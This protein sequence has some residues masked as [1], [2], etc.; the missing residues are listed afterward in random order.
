[1]AGCAE[2]SI[3]ASRRRPSRRRMRQRWREVK[4]VSCSTPRRSPRHTRL[5]KRARCS[6]VARREVMRQASRLVSQANCASKLVT[7]GGG[8]DVGGRVVMTS[9]RGAATTRATGL[10]HDRWRLGKFPLEARTTT[11]ASP[12]TAADV[13]NIETS[14][15]TEPY[16]DHR[17][18][19]RWLEGSRPCGPERRSVFRTMHATRWRG[20]E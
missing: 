3:S 6:H 1:M 19:Q 7:Y 13:C 5:P 14:E 16:H 9:N 12:V 15:A 4:E 11:M 2:R 18:G 17:E 20:S 8:R 10:L